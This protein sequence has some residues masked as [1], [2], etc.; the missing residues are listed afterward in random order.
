MPI[1][2]LKGGGKRRQDCPDSFEEGG[3]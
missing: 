2:Y 3:E 1:L